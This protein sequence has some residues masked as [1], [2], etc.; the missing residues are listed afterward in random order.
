MV[1]DCEGTTPYEIS[2]TTG[3]DLDLSN[4]AEV[5]DAAA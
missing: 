2:I 3:Y 5:G 1:I 4:I